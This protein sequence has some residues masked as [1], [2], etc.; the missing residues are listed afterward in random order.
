MQVVSA[1]RLVDGRT[2]EEE[3]VNRSYQEKIA[4]QKSEIVDLKVRRYSFLF[5]LTTGRHNWMRPKTSW[6]NWR[7][8]RHIRRRILRGRFKSYRKSSIVQWSR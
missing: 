1:M 8:N 5:S 6:N 3:R 2:E 4:I 7:N